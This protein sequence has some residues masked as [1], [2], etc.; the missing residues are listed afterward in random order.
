[1]WRNLAAI[2]TGRQWQYTQP[3]TGS[4]VRLRHFVDGGVNNTPY[5][6]KGAIVLSFN[7]AGSI[8]HTQYRSV[9]PSSNHDVYS[10]DN[11][12]P[13]REARIALRG[14]R[15]YAYAPN[16]IIYVDEWIEENNNNANSQLD[17]AI[18]RER[19]FYLLQ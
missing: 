4:I 15:R 19:E 6:F 9:Y 1:M 11:L 12:F 16:W 8:E 2:V 7:Y 10:F 14:Q 18:E 3:L 17:T 13:N 5:G